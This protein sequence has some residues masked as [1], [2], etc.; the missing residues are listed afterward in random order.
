VTKGDTDQWKHFNNWS[1]KK[2]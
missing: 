1:N 2:I